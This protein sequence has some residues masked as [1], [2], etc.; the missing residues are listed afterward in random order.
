ML[1][2]GLI[3]EKISPS[4]KDLPVQSEFFGPQISL[5][6]DFCIYKQVRKKITWPRT[7][8]RIPIR[9]LYRKAAYYLKGVCY[10]DLEFWPGLKKFQCYFA[11]DSRV[12]QKMRSKFHSEKQMAS[13]IEPKFCL[14]NKD[15]E[16]KILLLFWYVPTILVDLSKARVPIYFHK[17]KRKLPSQ[18]KFLPQP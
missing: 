5:T 2:F 11:D 7:S 17:L 9:I 6:G 14:S 16:S 1:Y 12:L 18:G 4:D 13:P 10:F 15:I 3:D 8:S